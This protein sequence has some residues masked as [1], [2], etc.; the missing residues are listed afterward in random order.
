MSPRAVQ[1]RAWCSSSSC[2]N[3][4]VSLRRGF[5]A[6]SGQTS[7]RGSAGLAIGVDR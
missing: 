5:G 4:H 6:A 7:V 1:W 2:V 3:R